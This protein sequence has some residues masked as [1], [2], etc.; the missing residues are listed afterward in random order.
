MFMDILPVVDPVSELIVAALEKTKKTE[1][2][3]GYWSRDVGL[4]S[5]YTANPS[6]VSVS[7][8]PARPA[9]P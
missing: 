1:R 6:R 2:D 4:P 9:I 7:E 5:R 8:Y 3:R